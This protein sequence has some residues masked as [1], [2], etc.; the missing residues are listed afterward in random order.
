MK[1]YI[2]ASL[3]LAA[4][5]IVLS[6]TKRS[7]ETA[8]MLAHEEWRRAAVEPETKVRPDRFEQMKWHA[9]SG[10]ELRAP[11]SNKKSRK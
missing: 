7:P 8:A 5:C 1:Y 3:L 9:D 10:V 2:A 4:F 11:A 6:Q